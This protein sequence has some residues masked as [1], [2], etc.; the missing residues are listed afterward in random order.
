MS[1]MYFV[2][3]DIADVSILANPPTASELNTAT[4]RSVQRTGTRSAFKTSP[5]EREQGN[6]RNQQAGLTA[7]LRVALNPPVIYWAAPIWPHSG[8]LCWGHG[9]KC[10]GGRQTANAA[11][12]LPGRY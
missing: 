11:T 10:K 8:M 4:I 7:E 1:A 6:R 12:D 5:T 9:P 3:G 2:A